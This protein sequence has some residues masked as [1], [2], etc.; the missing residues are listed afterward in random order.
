MS[1]HSATSWVR[2][3]EGQGVSTSGDSFYPD[4]SRP[5]LHQFCPSVIRGMEG[6]SLPTQRT[7]NVGTR[8]GPSALC[9]A[10]HSWHPVSS[11]CFLWPGL[12]FMGLTP[13]PRVSPRGVLILASASDKASWGGRC[14]ERTLG[15][16]SVWPPP[17][18]K[19]E[20]GGLLF[21]L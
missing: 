4:P 7:P 5:S 20:G 10:H 13:P 9:P 17:Q 16:G 3:P 14:L 12:P 1:C 11:G 18:P 19:L 15:A 2:S 6:N 21:R 8:S